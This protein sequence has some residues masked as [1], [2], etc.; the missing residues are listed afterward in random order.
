MSIQD[1]FKFNGAKGDVWKGKIE[2]YFFSRVPAVYELFNWA[3]NEEGPITDEHLQE[4]VGDGLTTIDWDG[5][6]RI[7]RRS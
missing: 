3:E 7:I 6:A 2:R 1:D 4:A 5:T